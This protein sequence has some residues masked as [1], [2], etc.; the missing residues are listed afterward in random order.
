[1]SDKAFVVFADKEYEIVGVR[2]PMK[3]EHFIGLGGDII[4]SAVDNPSGTIRTVLK[5][6]KWVPEV[7]E[8]YFV[9]TLEKGGICK[10]CWT[11]HSVDK[12]HL[13]QGL[14]CETEKE[15]EQLHAAIMGTVRDFRNS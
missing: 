11:D 2:A 9:P 4:L 10:L 8:W 3:G 7:D 6:V 1:M 14:I 15:A 12:Y 13:E 5:P